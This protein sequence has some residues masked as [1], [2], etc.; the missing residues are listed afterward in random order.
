MSRLL[1]LEVEMKQLMRNFRGT[2]NGRAIEHFHS[3][4]RP[5]DKPNVIS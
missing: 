5:Q 4:H 1:I 2:P 3:R